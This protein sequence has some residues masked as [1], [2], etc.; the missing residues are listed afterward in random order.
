MPQLKYIRVSGTRIATLD[1]T[2]IRHLYVCEAYCDDLVEL[3]INRYADTLYS[4]IVPTV[5]N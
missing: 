4:N 2:G 1:L 3:K 5:V